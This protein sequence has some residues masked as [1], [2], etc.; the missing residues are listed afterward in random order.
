MPG[1]TLRELE[2]TH[3]RGTRWKIENRRKVRDPESGNVLVLDVERIPD[4]GKF[5]ETL[6]YG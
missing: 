3:P 4:T 6:I 2:I 5:M 1:P